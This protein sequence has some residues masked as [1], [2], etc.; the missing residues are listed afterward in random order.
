[1]LFQLEKC[2]ILTARESKMLQPNRLYLLVSSLASQAAQLVKNLPAM[3]ETWVQSL[4]WEEPWRREWIL[5]PVFLSGEFYGQRR[6][7][8]L[9]SMESLRMGQ[10]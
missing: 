4:G 2:F 5:A 6:L 7:A 9:Q 3:W 10:D 1:M 8:G